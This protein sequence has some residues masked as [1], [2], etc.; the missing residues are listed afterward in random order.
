MT[1][2]TRT[3]FGLIAASALQSPGDCVRATGGAT[4]DAARRPQPRA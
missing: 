2:R 3:P 1:A 4:L